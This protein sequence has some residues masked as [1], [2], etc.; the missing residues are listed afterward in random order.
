MENR[1]LF[2]GRLFFDN[3]DWTV[4]TYEYI[5]VVAGPRRFANGQLELFFERKNPDQDSLG[6][7]IWLKCGDKKIK[8]IYRHLA[9]LY[10]DYV[11]DGI[12]DPVGLV[13]S[14][15]KENENS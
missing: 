7:D 3:E 6:N 2:E 15:E 9:L 4:P 8:A 10:L 14:K 13:K 11:R 12:L 1:L 5:R